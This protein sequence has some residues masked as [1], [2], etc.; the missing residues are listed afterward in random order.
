MNIYVGNL[1]PELTGKDLLSEFA[2][3]GRVTSVTIFDGKYI[4]GGR[5]KG[6]GFIEMPSV[7]EAQ[8]AINA[9]NGKRLKQDRINVI[10]ALPLSGKAKRNALAQ[11]S[12]SAR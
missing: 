3:F 4:G 2:P 9:L 6:H 5:S 10:E 1:S 8:A 11:K 7:L 12:V